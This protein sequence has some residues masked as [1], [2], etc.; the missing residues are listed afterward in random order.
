LQQIFSRM[1]KFSE[2]LKNFKLRKSTVPI[3]DFSDAKLAGFLTEQELQDY[4]SKVIQCNFE[5]WYELIKECTFETKTCDISFEEARLFVDVYKRLFQDKDPNEILRIDWRKSLSKTEYEVLANLESKLTFAIESFKR[6][7]PSELVFVKTSSRSAKDSPLATE[8]F[9]NLYLNFLNEL[10][11][12]KRS[13]ENEQITCML[14]AAFEC[15]KMKNAS[16][17]INSFIVSE[18][19]YQDM[20]LATEKIPR[21]K[22]HENFIIREFFH[23]DVDMEFRGRVCLKITYYAITPK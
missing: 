16:D 11:P 17:V 9:K 3:K 4:R 21:D 19:I 22:F 18:R 20:I 23:I 6:E 2:E 15:L 1:D 12:D 8:R 5:N 13:I 10:D 14:K 7:K